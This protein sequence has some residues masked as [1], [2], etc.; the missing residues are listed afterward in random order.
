[1]TTLNNE[2]KKISLISNVFKL[3][4]PVRIGKSFHEL[5]YSF[6]KAWTI[7]KKEVPLAYKFVCFI[8]NYL[9][10]NGNGMYSSN[11]A[12]LIL[13]VFFYLVYPYIQTF[14]KEIEILE[15]TRNADFQRKNIE[16][17]KKKVPTNWCPNFQTPNLFVQIIVWKYT[18]VKI[19]RSV[20]TR[21]KTI[22]D[23]V[24]ARITICLIN[25]EIL[26]ILIF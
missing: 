5:Y 22:N 21:A 2:R 4:G 18:N 3:K 11:C 1:M 6:M 20:S 23:C 9:P 26:W 14:E 24:R 12:L 25:S 8:W 17:E 16:T 13:A 10:L 19:G 7:N 15:Q